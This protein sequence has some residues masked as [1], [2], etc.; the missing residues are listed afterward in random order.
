VPVD[1][2]TGVP[3]DTADDVA[4]A[5]TVVVVVGVVGVLDDDEQPATAAAQATAATAMASRAA[6]AGRAVAT[7]NTDVPFIWVSARSPF[8]NYDDAAGVSVGAAD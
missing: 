2:G 7:E 5:V 8:T 3:P 1:A 4:V 6:R